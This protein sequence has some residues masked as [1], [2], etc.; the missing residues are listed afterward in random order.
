[1]RDGVEVQRILVGYTKW[2][3]EAAAAYVT[4]VNDNVVREL[5][6]NA[7]IE[8]VGGRGTLRVKHCVEGS[9]QIV[10]QSCGRTDCWNDPVGERI[11]ERTDHDGVALTAAV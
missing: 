10:C 8:I 1:M 9:A 11:V 3:K 6:F 5:I 7:K 2:E 4:D